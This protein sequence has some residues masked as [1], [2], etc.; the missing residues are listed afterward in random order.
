MNIMADFNLNYADPWQATWAKTMAAFWVKEGL[1][2]Y[3]DTYNLDGS[4]KASTH[5]AGPTAMR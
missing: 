2:S 1:A 5:G 4:G 3:G